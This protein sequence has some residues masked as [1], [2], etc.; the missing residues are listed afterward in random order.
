M[1][2]LKFGVV[3]LVTTT[4]DFAIFTALTLGVHVAPPLA[5][6]VSYSS[7]IALSFWSNRSWTFR[8]RTAGRSSTQLAMFTTGSLVG[9]AFSTITVA[10]L[11]PQ[12]GP[13]LAKVAA[14]G[15]TFC[16]NYLFSNLVVF[17]K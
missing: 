10:L 1:R 12:Y 15:V 9:L 13:L 6:M 4:L 16:W 3:G 5:N 2:A 7:G 8:D 14:I 11:A 17:R